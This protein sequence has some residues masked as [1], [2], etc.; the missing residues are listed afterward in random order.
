MI[1]LAIIVPAAAMY[2][3][4]TMLALGQRSRSVVS[5]AL[6]NTFLGWTIVGWAAALLWAAFGRSQ[7]QD[8]RNVA[9][10]AEIELF[11]PHQWLEVG[12]IDD[13]SPAVEFTSARLRT[14][15]V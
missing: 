6:L 11:A 9:G 14:P 1:V 13:F 2:F 10:R 3:S 5:I 8:A 4:P 12:E 15:H 7:D